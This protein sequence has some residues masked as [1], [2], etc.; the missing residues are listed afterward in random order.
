MYALIKDH[1]VKEVS[2]GKCT[3][4]KVPQK[5]NSHL[6]NKGNETTKMLF[7]PLPF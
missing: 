4:L 6:S 3:F 5:Q 1:E 2:L 7:L